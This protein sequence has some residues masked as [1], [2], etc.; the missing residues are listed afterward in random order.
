MKWLVTLILGNWAVTNNDYNDY[1]DDI[2]TT[3]TNY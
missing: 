2:T 3:S 1:N